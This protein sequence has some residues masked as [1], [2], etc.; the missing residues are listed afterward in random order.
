MKKLILA[1]LLAASTLAQA[2]SVAYLENKAG[3]KIVLATNA[4]YIN[5]ERFDP[6]LSAWT[7]TKSGVVT[8]GCWVYEDATDLVHVVWE[9]G[10]RRVYPS[11]NFQRLKP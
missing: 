10:E 4:C 6:L 7:H 8:T 5:G 3:G 2:E 1:A 9:D 11:G